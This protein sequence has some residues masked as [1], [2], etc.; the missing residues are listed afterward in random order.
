MSKKL[1]PADE[2]PDS[3]AK[4]E[5]L[6]VKTIGVDVYVVLHKGLGTDKGAGQYFVWPK[7]L[8]SEVVDRC[9]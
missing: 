3:F 8:N 1:R 7:V 5:I 6:D 4:S 2:T 9:T